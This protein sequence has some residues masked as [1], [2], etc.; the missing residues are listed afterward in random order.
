M[1][2]S[3]G[4]RTRGL[5]AA[6]LTLLVVGCSND[7]RSSGEAR[8]LGEIERRWAAVQWDT[9][10]VVGGSADDTLLYLPTRLAADETGVSVLDRGAGQVLRIDRHGRLIWRFGRRGRGP[11]EFS[12]PRDIKLDRLGASWVLDPG[13]ARLV[14][15]DAAGQTAVTIPLSALSRPADAFI[16]GRPGETLLLTLDRERPL[17]RLSSKGE[18]IER[19]E[20]P[21]PGFS[22]LHPLAAQLVTGHD[23]RSERWVAAFGLGDG[24]FVFRGLRWTGYRGRYVE[25]AEFPR[26]E[27]KRLSNPGR[28][29][30]VAHVR[31]ARFTAEAISISEDR[32]FVFFGGRSPDR[33]RLMD[34]YSAEDGTYLESYRLPA[35]PRWAVYAGGLVYALY[36]DPYPTLAAWR[37]KEHQES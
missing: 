13:N 36:E 8:T 18:V 2:S 35:Q 16:P 3:L 15:I 23:P 21:W 9:V 14:R 27:E 1:T 26:V 6:L 10:F 34:I 28:S 7:N 4:A 19:L 24:F 29:Q 5:T 32:L 33:H 11:T 25:S 37:P 17:V 30:Q 12:R 20:F 22:S 31:G